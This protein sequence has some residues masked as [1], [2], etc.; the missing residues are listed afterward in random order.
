MDEEIDAI[1]SMSDEEILKG[2]PLYARRVCEVDAPG[3][4]LTAKLV[5]TEEAVQDLITICRAPV[6]RARMG[7]YV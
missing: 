7:K 5:R 1:L 2:L 3:I 4:E 6:E